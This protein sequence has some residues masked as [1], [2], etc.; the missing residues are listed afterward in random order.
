MEVFWSWLKVAISWPEE[1]Q[2]DF[3]FPDPHPVRFFSS[4]RWN[5]DNKDGHRFSRTFLVLLS[6][7]CP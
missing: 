5:I 3:I 2:F 6:I 1:R 7:Y 4:L